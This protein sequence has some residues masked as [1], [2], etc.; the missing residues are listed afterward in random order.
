MEQEKRKLAPN[1]LRA[2]INVFIINWN[3]HWPIDYWWRKKYKIPFGSKQHREADFIT[4]YLDYEE[5]RMMKQFYEKQSSESTDKEF[6]E[7]F[8][9]SGVGKK[10]TQEEID[11]DFENLDLSSYNTTKGKD[12]KDG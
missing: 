10:M 1:S 4:M 5:E 11:D 7:Q 2:E 9:E 3:K 6:E 12:K 8:K